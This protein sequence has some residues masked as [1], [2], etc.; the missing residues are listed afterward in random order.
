MIGGVVR[1]HG[2]VTGVTP[3][4]VAYAA[5]D[6]VLLDWVQ[7]TAGYG[8]IEAYKRFGHPLSA[9][10]EDRAYAEAKPGARLYGAM[11]SPS[12]RAELD[13]QFEAMRPHL[14]DSAIVHEFLDIMRRAPILPPLLKPLQHMMLHAAVDML[15]TW[16]KTLLHLENAGLR[17]LEG[18]ILRR[19]GR[20]ADRI[21]I[22]NSPAAQASQR[23]GLPADHVY[24]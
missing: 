2:H 14:E 13:A 9:S 3:A 22:P 21:V 20:F 24:R 17:P 1:R 11:N 7:T 4:G 12:S 10:D 8:F 6:P 19:A 15:P 18:A 23:L 16:A 5:N